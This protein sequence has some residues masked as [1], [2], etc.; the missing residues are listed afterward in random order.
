MQWLARSH[1]QRPHD[2]N[3]TAPRG[4]LAGKGAAIF[5]DTGLAGSVDCDLRDRRTAPEIVTS[6]GSSLGG[7]ALR[8]VYDDARARPARGSVRR[9]QF[10]YPDKVVD[11]VDFTSLPLPGTPNR[12]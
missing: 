7:P 6:S 1:L 9:F 11:K 4:S 10:D 2:A 3:N 5:T 12:L 8:Q